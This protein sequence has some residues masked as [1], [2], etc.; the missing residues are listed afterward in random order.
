MTTKFKP[1]DIV[2]IKSGS[3]KMTVYSSTPEGWT[4]CYYYSEE[5]KRI[6]EAIKLPSDILQLAN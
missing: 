6:M 4:F 3:P 1:G 2:I 5:E